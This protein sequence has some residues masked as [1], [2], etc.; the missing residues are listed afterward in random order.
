MALWLKENEN[1]SDVVISTRVRLARNLKGLPFPHVI[2][3]TARAERVKQVAKDAFVQPGMDFQ[4]LEMKDLSEINKERYVE[5]H[6]ISRELADLPD[7]AI[8]LS[9]DESIS[10]MLLEEDHFRLQC[11]KSG[12][13]VEGA[14]KAATELEHMLGRF[15]EFAFDDELGYLTSCPTNVGTGLRIG[16]MLHLPALTLTGGVGGVLSSLGNFGLTVRGMYG[17]GT[18]AGAAV[19]QISNQVT[20]GA[21]EKAIANNLLAVVHEIIRREREAR[22]CIA[23]SRSIE[24]K[25]RV[26]R[27]YGALKY[28]RLI[29]AGEALTRIS[30]VCLGIGLGW[31]EEK[32]DPVEL[33]GLMMDIMPGMLAA[34][35]RSAKDRD[36]TRADIIR[37]TLKS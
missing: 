25:D 11:M 19:Y 31:M 9:P 5:Q 29:D 20:L 34:E 33:Y 1:D 7:A 22:E 8:V 28:A 23:A 4:F 30:D 14:L 3:G 36:R 35:G 26:L 37:A 18:E 13:D 6:V 32:L 17:E 27:S 24:V 10:V 12:L 15:A 16:V 2:R 21:S